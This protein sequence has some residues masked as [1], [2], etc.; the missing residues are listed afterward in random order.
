MF[1]REDWMKIVCKQSFEVREVWKSQS[2]LRLEETHWELVLQ[3]AN[4]SFF[5][6]CPVR[7]YQMLRNVQAFS[8]HQ[9]TMAD[10][11]IVDGMALIKNEKMLQHCIVVSVTWCR[12][13]SRSYVAFLPEEIKSSKRY[14]QPMFSMGCVPWSLIDGDGWVRGRVKENPCQDSNE[15]NL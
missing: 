9:S 14:Y 11:L 5:V 15:R 13:W 6:P 7:S 3:K 4:H 8:N 1:Q 2:N 10:W 12:P